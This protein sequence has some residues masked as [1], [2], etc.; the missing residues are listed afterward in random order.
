ML[1][2]IRCAAISGPRHRQHD[3]AN[4]VP[5]IVTIMPETG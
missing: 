5:R 1:S 2:Q 4:A 3:D